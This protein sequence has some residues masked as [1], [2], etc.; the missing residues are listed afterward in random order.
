MSQS[1]SNIFVD[2]YN[3]LFR[4]FGYERVYLP[5]DIVPDT[6]FRIQ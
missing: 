6:P 5:L 3:F 1:K 4:P 2:L